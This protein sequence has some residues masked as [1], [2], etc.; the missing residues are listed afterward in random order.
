[1]D[2]E[3]QEK[4][5]QL[6][7]DTNRK[8]WFEARF[9]KEL[10]EDVLSDEGYVDVYLRMDLTTMKANYEGYYLNPDL[11]RHKLLLKYHEQGFGGPHP[12][13]EIED[14]QTAVNPRLLPPGVRVNP[15]AL[16]NKLYYMSETDQKIYDES[17]DLMATVTY[18]VGIIDSRQEVVELS[19]LL[20]T[21]PF[22]GVAVQALDRF[23]EGGKLY[24]SH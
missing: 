1:M 11:I 2:P 19:L 18:N 6:L 9:N 14:V 8:E 4:K 17:L 3:A 12:D 21:P 15:V 5:R 13:L 7:D 20:A 22:R 10:Q 16:E 23:V 24:I